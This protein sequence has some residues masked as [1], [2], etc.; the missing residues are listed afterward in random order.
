MGGGGGLTR[1]IGPSSVPFN[2]PIG[3]YRQRQSRGPFPRARPQTWRCRVFGQS[4]QGTNSSGAGR[5]RQAVIGGTGKERIACVCTLIRTHSPMILSKTHPNH[6][7]FRDM[8]LARSSGKA[9]SGPIAYT[10]TPTPTHTPTHTPTPT[11]TNT[12]TNKK[13]DKHTH[14][15]THTHTERERYMFCLQ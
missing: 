14:T 5:N 15:H 13:K 10:P 9:A 6:R 12:N 2:F 11:N 1:R 4:G 3:P 7:E 8:L